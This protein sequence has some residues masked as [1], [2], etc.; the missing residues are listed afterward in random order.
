[1]TSTQVAPGTIIQTTCRACGAA[2]LVPIISFG[3]TPLADHLIT[4]DQ[5]TEPEIVA[6]LDLVLCPDCAL[7]QITATVPP[8]TLFG[9]DYPYYSSVS[10]SLMQHFMSSATEIIATRRLG[11]T[12][13]VVEPAS[14]DGYMLRTFARAGIPVLGIDPA[15]G[16]TE[17]ALKQGIPTLQ[18]FFTRE[19]ALRL[20]NEGIRADVVL[21]NNVLAHVANLNGFVE[22]IR[23]LLKEDGVA[24]MEVP[25]LADL[26]ARCE[27]DTIY[28]QHLCYFTVT[29]LA[30]LF[31]SNG[32]YLKDV[33][34]VAIHGGSLRL[35]VGHRRGATD[36]VTKLLYEEKEQG[37]STELFYRQF[38]KRV[39]AIRA[40]LLEMLHDIK[41]QGGRIAAYGAAAKATTLLSY[42]G[43]DRQ[44]VD[45]VVDL[46][47]YK[48]GKYM[49]GSRIC[50]FPTTRL[51]D[52]MP[53]SVLLLA[54]NFADE[55]M[56]QQD[57]YR[58]RG[59]RF[60]IPIP[61]PRIA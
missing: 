8:E 27:F 32:L 42:V 30:K 14:N 36:A 39:A 16:P 5:L 22:G 2:G 51:L 12:S 34:R 45:Y 6:P 60:I 23:I 26:I 54:W 4:A 31:R 18:T 41:Q 52:D 38:A 9:G 13:F 20:C 15:K 47:P 3:L 44:L 57:E 25:Y 59:G 37:I 55:I 48:H 56:R 7:V 19:I 58:R 50:I 24:V 1:M 35:F 21:A 53:E 40:S 61:E 28:H 11:P 46:N 43:I 29:S 10:P 17:A 49:P 33:R